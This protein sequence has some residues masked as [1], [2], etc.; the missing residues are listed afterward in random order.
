MTESPP[1]KPF[2]SKSRFVLGV[3]CPKALYLKVHRPELEAPVGEDMEK[4]FRTGTEVGLRATGE[5]PG[6]VMIETEFWEIDKAL[7]LT[8]RAIDAGAPAIFEAAV[9]HEGVVIR[10]DILRRNGDAWDLIEVKS[11]TKVKGVHLSDVALQVHVARAASYRIRSASVMVLNR[12]CRFPELSNLFRIEDVTEGIERLLPQVPA[13]IYSLKSMLE[14]PE[15]PACAIGRHCSEPHACGFQAHCRTHLPALGTIFDLPGSPWKLY[16]KGLVLLK[17]LKPS[18]VSAAQRWPLQVVQSG[19]P[20]IKAAPIREALAGW[21]YPRYYLDFETVQYAVPVFAGQRPYDQTPIQFSVQVQGSA[22]D[23]PEEAAYLHGDGTDPRRALAEALTRAIPPS[24]GIVIAYAHQFEKER[25]HELAD[26]APDL[27]HHL[28]SIAARLVDPLPIVRD[29]VYHPGFRG[30]R[31]IKQVAP[32]LLGASAGYEGMEVPDGRA[33]GRAFFR[34]IA[35]ETAA[36]EQ[37]ALRQAMLEYCRKDTAVMVRL[38]E[39][40][41]AL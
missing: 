41:E 19:K 34:M 24:G 37:A 39:W 13:R 16:E 3:Q 26:A 14:Q 17:D 15:A 8:R 32:A 9:Q 25:L 6:G 4:V 7:V 23:S 36:T 31:S 20:G 11:S 5:F 33:A 12:E 22:G 35:P 2:L 1:Q 40:L 18:D 27:S 29:S 10:V 30:S 21:G 38:V 28:L